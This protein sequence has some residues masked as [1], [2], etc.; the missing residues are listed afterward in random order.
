MEFCVGETSLCQFF[1]SARDFAVVVGYVVGRDVLVLSC[2]VLHPLLSCG[3]FFS[4][5]A[6][7]DTPPAN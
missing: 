2:C 1:C 7:R 3:T 4:I 5:I 6:F